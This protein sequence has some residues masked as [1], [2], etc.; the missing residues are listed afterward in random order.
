MDGGVANH[1]PISVAARLGAST[2]YVLHRL[3]LRATLA[4]PLRRLGLA[5][6]ARTLILRQRLLAD[7]ATHEASVRLRV[8]PPLCPLSV[9]P[10]DFARPDDLITRARR[11]SLRLARPARSRRHDTPPAAPPPR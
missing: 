2:I 6:H 8:L 9:S 5:L 11:D 3:R 1:T 4:A 10:A 7:I